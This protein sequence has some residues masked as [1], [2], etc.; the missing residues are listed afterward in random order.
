M[1]LKRADEVDPVRLSHQDSAFKYPQLSV[2]VQFADQG[3]GFTDNPGSLASGDAM[4]ELVLQDDRMH[5]IGRRRSWSSE[6]S[7]GVQKTESSESSLRALRGSEESALS[8]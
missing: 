8:A 2:V 5:R 4:N 3:P 1:N 6:R 7:L